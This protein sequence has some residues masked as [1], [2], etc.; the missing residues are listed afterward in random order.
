MKL[1]QT[2]TAVETNNVTEGNTFGIKSSPKTF[3][4]LSSGLYSDKIAAV[5]RELSCNAYD[6]HVDR[7]K[8]IDEGRATKHTAP[9]DKNIRVHFPSSFD[10][11][12]SV[13]DFGI[14][15]SPEDV[16]NIYTVYFES[17]KQDSNDY[18]GALGLGSK[19]PFSYA[20]SFNVIATKNGHRVVYTMFMNSQGIPQPAKLD[21]GPVESF[22]TEDE[23]IPEEEFYDGVEVKVP[24][25]PNDAGSFYSAAEY[26]YRFFELC[27]EL[28]NYRGDDIT[29]YKNI[30]GVEEFI[31]GVY[32]GDSSYRSR[33]YAIQGNVAYPIELSQNDFNRAVRDI[34]KFVDNDDEAV[35]KQYQFTDTEIQDLYKF[36]KGVFTDYTAYIK[37]NIGDLDVAASREELSYDASTIMAILLQLKRISDEIENKFTEHMEKFETKWDKARELMRIA[38]HH[39]RS[40]DQERTS[41]DRLYRQTE[42]HV[43]YLE[44]ENI[45]Q[46]QVSDSWD[47]TK[48]LSYTTSYSTLSVPEEAD[49]TIRMCGNMS[50][51]R[52]FQVHY[53]LESPQKIHGFVGNNQI[54]ALKEQLLIVVNDTKRGGATLAKAYFQQI[55]SKMYCIL[56]EP[57][58][59]GNIEGIQE[60][61][62]TSELKMD[63]PG[64]EVVYLSKVKEDHP[65]LSKRNTGQR[66]NF[67]YYDLTESY[68]NVLHINKSIPDDFENEDKIIYIPFKN[69]KPCIDNDVFEKFEGIVDHK[70]ETVDQLLRTLRLIFLIT[71]VHYKVIGLNQNMLRQVPEYD[72]WESLDVFVYDSIVDLYGT[73]S[74]RR[75]VE[76]S[77]LKKRETLDIYDSVNLPICH[78]S[79][80]NL[81]QKAKEHEELKDL[82]EIL[83]ILKSSPAGYNDKEE[84][85]LELFEQTEPMSP[86]VDLIQT[87]YPMLLLM[88]SE[89]SWEALKDEELEQ[90]INYCKMCNQGESK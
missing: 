44:Y 55:A 76:Q 16:E 12:F 60:Y 51:K 14:G 52:F 11:F 63:N 15:L 86:K 82:A 25:E 71:G 89:Y 3:A 1:K 79:V 61:I 30:N 56:L 46:L 69:Q 68:R 18:I 9:Q 39:S 85:L 47:R 41:L 26:V 77:I 8:L 87:K 10:P 78:E 35:D 5:V 17:T 74:K 66:S 33:Q 24:A 36:Y 22:Y 21:E 43:D 42:S 38:G 6:S 50:N 23:E 48:S 28:E 75:P 4:I 29:Y 62:E 80:N 7:N 40:Y 81:Y 58:K 13:R 27:P 73:K 49:F 59:Y 72:N 31:D 19:S 70:L 37:F 64:L 90:V 54:P 2:T 57:E 34:D 84:L 53:N 65:E 67:G 88:R 20:Q 83:K 45:P 32:I